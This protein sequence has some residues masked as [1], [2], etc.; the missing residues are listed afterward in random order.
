MKKVVAILGL[1]TISSSAL[2]FDKIVD[3]NRIK[4]NTSYPK[5][6]EGLGAMIEELITNQIQAGYPKII[7]TTATKV[8][9]LDQQSDN[10]AVAVCVVA[11]KK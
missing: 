7:S 5:S 4:C 10:G 1:L 11:A 8:G 9:W 3:A 2:A 6:G